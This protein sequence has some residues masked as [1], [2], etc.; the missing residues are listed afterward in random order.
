LTRSPIDSRLLRADGDDS[1]S[2]AGARA[3]AAPPAEDDEWTATTMRVLFVNHTSHMSGAEYSLLELL[4]R[5]TSSLRVELA[6]P[7]GPLMDAARGRSLSVHAITGTDGS[8]M[9]HPR[10]TSRALAEIA[11]AALE[12]RRLRGAL[13]VDLVHANSIRAG[14]VAGLGGA[15]PHTG[16]RSAGARLSGGG[17]AR[18]V[19]VVAHVRDCL[20]DGPVSS[21][22]M[23]LLARRSMVLI[24]NS[25]YTRDRSI[26]VAAR[27]RTE[28]VHSPCDLDRFDPAPIDRGAARRALGLPA[29]APVLGVVAQITPWKGQIDAVRMLGE[30]SGAHPDALLLVVGSTKFTSR[31]TRYDNAGYLERIRWEVAA[32]GLGGRVRL[33]GE[34]E[35]VP[36]VLRALDLLLVPS[37]E[38][39]FGRSV[40][41]GMAMGVPV[42]ATARGGPAEI[43]RDGID[44]RTLPPRDPRGW[45][46]VSAELLSDP[47]RR[48]AMGVAARAR[49]QERFGLDSHVAGV[50]RVYARAQ[51]MGTDTQAQGMGT[52]TQARGMGTDTQAQGMGADT[53]ALVDGA[54]ETAP[55]G[56]VG[57]A[58]AR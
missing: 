11:R 23:R 50:M 34:R 31:A 19:P 52:D 1:E 25:A 15:G 28:V 2:P 27:E 49:A 3:A 33:V 42:I 12:T 20:P 37:W 13:G 7:P 44:G 29:L 58:R 57:I 53:P 51:G 41:E 30:M 45:A 39:P 36:V 48:A 9:L 18:A 4:Q 26:P 43:L 10:H 40:V 8:L 17:Q 55:S 5:L 35:D 24:A 38:E 21:A 6:C 16:S 47:A 32:L 46:R 54:V 14:I 22:T 56:A